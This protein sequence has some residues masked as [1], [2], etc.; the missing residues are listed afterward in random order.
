MTQHASLFRRPTQRNPIHSQHRRQSEAY[1]LR[2]LPKT[3]SRDSEGDDRT[4]DGSTCLDG[5]RPLAYIKRDLKHV[6]DVTTEDDD[7]Y[8]EL[9]HDD[10][11]HKQEKH[12]AYI[13]PVQDDAYIQPVQDDAYVKPMQDDGYFQ[14]LQLDHGYFQPTHD[15]GYF[16]PLQLDDACTPPLQLDDGYFPPLHLD[17]DYDEPV[18][19]SAATEPVCTE[20]RKVR[21]AAAETQASDTAGAYLNLH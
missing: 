9:Q 21:A 10:A 1:A 7:V 14:P 3:L 13:Q 12:A 18:T 2:P 15:D 19:G 5:Q 6:T 17:D 20:V 8:E 4:R 16:P 11:K